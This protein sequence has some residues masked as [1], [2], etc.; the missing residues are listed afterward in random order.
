MIKYKEEVIERFE[1]KSAGE[2]LHQFLNFSNS[3]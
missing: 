1:N 2:S 3:L